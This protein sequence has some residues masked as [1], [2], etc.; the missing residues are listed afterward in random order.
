MWFDDVKI[1]KGNTARTVI[2][3][4]SNYYPFGMLQRGYN[5]T[6]NPNGNH[7]ANK[8]KYNGIELEESLGLNVYEMNWRGYDA[9]LGRWMNIDPLAEEMRR[10]SPYNFAFDNPVYFIDPGGMM[11]IGLGDMDEEKN[12]DFK[13]SNLPTPQTS[14]YVDPSGKIIKHID[15]GDP[16][17]YLVNDPDN[18]DGTSDGLAVI[19][20]EREGVTYTPGN[21]IVQEDLNEGFFLIDGY[22]AAQLTKSETVVGGPGILNI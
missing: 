20:T 1:V 21:T 6:I 22:L 8:F 16:N 4:E 17:I 10:Y 19:R 2:V 12:F 5:S 9:S 7:I 11:P 14:T 15:D 18:W 3:S 13:P